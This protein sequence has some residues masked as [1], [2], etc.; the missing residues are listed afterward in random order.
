[1]LR[2]TCGIAPR[3]VGGLRRP[4]TPLETPFIRSSRKALDSLTGSINYARRVSGEASVL[5]SKAEYRAW[6]TQCLAMASKARRTQD[7]EAWLKLSEKWRLLAGGNAPQQA[8]QPQPE[9]L[10]GTDLP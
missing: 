2:S 7:K 9:R 5:E 4:T 1:M 8:E 10:N 6:A 3:T